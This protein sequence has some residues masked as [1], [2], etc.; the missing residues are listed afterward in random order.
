[1]LNFAEDLSYREIAS[2]LEI[3]IGTVMSRLHRARK[4]LQRKLGDYALSQG[5]KPVQR[6]AAGKVAQGG[7][8][9]IE[10]YK[11]QKVG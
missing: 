10:K 9:D 11:Q 2:V 7:L 5:I 4:T 1:V 3:P 8:V 6:G